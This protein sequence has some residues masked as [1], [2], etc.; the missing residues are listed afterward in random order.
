VKDPETIAGVDVAYSKSDSKVAASAVVFSFKSMKPVE[1]AL[2]DDEDAA[3]YV[4]G[5]FAQREL[6]FLERVLALLTVKP[7]III[8]DAQGFAHPERN[9]LACRLGKL[10]NIPV[11]G[12]A[13]TRLIGTYAE[14]G[15]SR[16]STS[17]LTDNGEV[18][19]T[20]LRTQ[21][22]INPVFVSVGYNISLEDATAIVLKSSLHYRIPEPLRAADHVGRE[23]LKQLTARKE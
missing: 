14:P 8:C 6:P 11:I 20:V 18:I 19:G 15:Q 5:M 1:T 2:F 13:K 22:S 21:D 17:P 10:V 16:G 3:P 9:G 12:C 4:P 23:R 7:D